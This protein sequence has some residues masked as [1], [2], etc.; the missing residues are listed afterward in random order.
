MA[1]RVIVFEAAAQGEPALADVLVTGGC[2]VSRASTTEALVDAVLSGPHEAVLFALGP[3]AAEDLAALRV[4]R[5]LA[6]D[7]PLIVVASDSSL[8]L[9]RRIQP[10]RPIYFALRP[11]D[12][13]ELCAAVHDACASLRRSAA[14]ANGAD[15][16]AGRA[17]RHQGHL[18]A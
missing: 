3:G 5:R 13:E 4:L 11:V 10:L 6:P 17:G 15:H 2:E 16:P 14:H 12:A 1:S 7:L 9:R 8:D 18:P